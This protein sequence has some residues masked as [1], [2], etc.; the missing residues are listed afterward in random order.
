MATQRAELEWAQTSGLL[1]MIDNITGGKKTPDD[2]NPLKEG[3]GRAS[4]GI[5]ITADNIQVLK[6]LLPGGAS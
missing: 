5:P 1:A 6:A 4:S 3:R 2:F